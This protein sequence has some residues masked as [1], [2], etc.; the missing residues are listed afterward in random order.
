MSD[1]VQC[2]K[3]GSL[4]EHPTEVKQP[5]GGIIDVGWKCVNCGHEWGF[6]VYKKEGEG[7]GGV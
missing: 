5:G 7:N 4:A 2:P 6:E 3:C 1:R